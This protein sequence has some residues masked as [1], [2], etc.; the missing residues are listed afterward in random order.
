[1][2]F[3]ALHVMFAFTLNAFSL[4][5]MD[6]PSIKCLQRPHLG[7]LHFV[8]LKSSSGWFVNFAFVSKRFRLGG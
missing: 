6:D 7:S 1:M 3:F 5:E 8:T 4:N 2:T